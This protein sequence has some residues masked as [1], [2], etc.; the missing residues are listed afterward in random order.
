MKKL[1]ILFDFNGTMLF[2]GPLHERAWHDFAIQVRGKA[3]SSEEMAL[4]HGKVNVKIIEYLKPSIANEEAV[5]L[6]SAK[7]AMYRSICLKQP[8]DF[9]L[10]A[11]LSDF[12][13]ELKAHQIFCNIASAS[14]KENIDF[15]VESFQLE[16][17]FDPAKI[18]YDDGSY[19]DKVAMFKDAAKVIGRKIEDCI[20]FEDSISGIDCA[21]HAGVKRIIAI[22]PRENHVDLLKR[23][24]VIAAIEDF[25]EINLTQLISI[26][27][28]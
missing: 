8:E 25:R 19:I 2:D 27:N 4:M 7:E 26:S 9:Q 14:I 6:S 13:D 20:V 22:T 1:T 17:W 3:F 28:S 23:D 16:R 15:F 5:A 24:G 11:G 18:I 21:Y 10:V 12:L